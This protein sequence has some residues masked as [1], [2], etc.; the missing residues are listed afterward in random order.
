MDFDLNDDQKMLA[1]TVASFSKQTSPVSRFRKLRDDTI[2]WEPAIWKQMAELGWLAVAFP[3]AA[4]GYG[5]TFVD[6]AIILEKLGTTLVPE[7]FIP[8]VVLA[9]SAIALAGSDEQQQRLLGPMLE[10]STSLALA[11]AERGGR[12]DLS[13]IETTASEKNG[14]WHLTG[15]KMFVLNGHAADHFVVSARTKAGV[16]LFAIPRSETGVR[17]EPLFLLDGRRGANLSLSDA[18]AELLAEDGLAPLERVIDRGAAAACAEGVG[19]CQTV[20]G[21]TIEQLKLRKQF[22][23]QIGTFQALQHRAVDM[24]VE[25][26]LMRSMSLTASVMVDHPD[27]TARRRDVSMAKAQLAVGGKLVTQQSIQLHGGIGITDEHDVGLYF[28]RMH[29]LNLLFGDEAHHLT[30]IAE[31]S[32]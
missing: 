30:R 12:Y 14:R 17:I 26:E 4:G 28:K 21:M 9:G 16:S 29:A 1:E 8:S 20:L 3:E 2:G 24:F 15:E 27:D 6:L 13:A 22:G 19:I 32:G 23:V 7:P 31:A 11:Y 5:G 18:P 25:V 10:G